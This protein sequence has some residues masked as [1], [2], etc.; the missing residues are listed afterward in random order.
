[1]AILTSFSIP[2]FCGQT[3]S[4]DRSILIWQ[5]LVENAKVKIQNE[6][7]WVIF[8]QCVF[9][10]LCKMNEICDFGFF[11][12]KITPLSHFS[13]SSWQ[14]CGHFDPYYIHRVASHRQVTKKGRRRTT[15]TA[16]FLIFLSCW[17]GFVHSV[18]NSWRHSIMSICCGPGYA[19]PREAFLKGETEKL[20]YIPCIIPGKDRP[21]YLSTVDIDPASPTFC[22]VWY[23]L[24]ALDFDLRAILSERSPILTLRF[25]LKIKYFA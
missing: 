20:L 1:M 24:K 16:T 23:L 4:P 13:H 15:S 22:K 3:V 6:T 9:V 5:K 10:L 14:V 21:D 17:V 11:I 18:T 8:K 2:E 25:S 12:K 19:S 7:F